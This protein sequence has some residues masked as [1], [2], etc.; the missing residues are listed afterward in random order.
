MGKRRESGQSTELGFTGFH[1]P[2]QGLMHPQGEAHATACHSDLCGW[3]SLR[4][5]QES[6]RTS[7]DPGDILDSPQLPFCWLVYNPRTV[8]P[9]CVGICGLGA[10]TE[11]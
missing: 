6:S 1:L 11:A 8:F 10:V 3:T 9:I 5:S 7:A 4:G 2:V